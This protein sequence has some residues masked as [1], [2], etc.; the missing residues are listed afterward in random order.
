M[1][2]KI[3]EVEN[4]QTFTTTYLGETTTSEVEKTIS[5]LRTTE[6]YT[7]FRISNFLDNTFV[8]I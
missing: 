8:R 1:Q 6:A 2:R 5:F 7:E 4:I 3:Q